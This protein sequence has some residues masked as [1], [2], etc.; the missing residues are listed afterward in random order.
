MRS[1][2]LALGVLGLLMASC[3][4]LAPN[5]TPIFLAKL[6]GENVVPKIT[7]EAWGYAN[8][9]LSG[10]DLTLN[11]KFFRLSGKAT[12]VK[13]MQG[14]VGQNSAM[15]AV[16]TF[17]PEK[18]IQNDANK[19]GNGTFGKT[20]TFKDHKINEDVVKTGGYYLVVTTETHPDGE[21][22]GQLGY[23]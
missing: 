9:T 22:R 17:D 11:G 3:S 14:K 6:S 23:E 13:L 12:G 8:G 18:E 7:S 15:L 2:T 5:T 19:V 4:Q 21:L 10:N 16:C 1:R 20:C